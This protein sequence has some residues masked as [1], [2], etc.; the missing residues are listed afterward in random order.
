MD[1][2]RSSIVTSELAA[3]IERLTAEI[4]GLEK[5]KQLAIEQ[6]SAVEV[7]LALFQN[8]KDL[9]PVSTQTAEHTQPSN[10]AHPLR[11]AIYDI[12]L[13]ANDP[14]HRR[15]IHDMLVKNRIVIG[16]KDPLNNVGAH[17]SL[18][19]RFESNGN[20]MWQLTERPSQ[21]VVDAD[22]D[23]EEEEENVPW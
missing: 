12:L 2:S 18:D 23:L 21:T 4:D 1:N 11:D 15:D 13:T 17:L 5:Q 9:V 7:T 20:G 8:P 16:G 3:Q 19:P 14:L 6:R 22:K 10:S